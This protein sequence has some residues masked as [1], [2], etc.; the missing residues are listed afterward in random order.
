MR[1]G[2]IQTIVHDSIIGK[3]SS[4]FGVI[5]GAQDCEELGAVLVDLC[6]SYP[7]NLAESTHGRG[8]LD[9]HFSEGTV[10]EHYI[11]RN[12]CLTGNVASQITEAS[13]QCSIGAGEFGR[14]LGGRG[15][16][17]FR[18]WAWV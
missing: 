7:I 18:T 12:V 6:W 14:V 17:G 4:G 2:E 5:G 3:C 10:S 11:S 9:G 13:Q 15:W 1:L 8:A 16:P